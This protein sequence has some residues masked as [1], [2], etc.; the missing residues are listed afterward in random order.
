MQNTKYDSSDIKVLN[1]REHVRLRTNIYLGSTEPTEFNIP[2]FTNDKFQIKKIE[3]IPSV[4]KAVNEIL[5]NS[6]DE[7]AQLIKLNKTLTINSN[8][9]LGEYSISDNGRGIP[10]DMHETGKH[11]PEVVF[12]SLR[13][14][15][16]F[17]NERST[18]VIGVNGVGSSCT[19]YCSSYFHVNIHRDGKQYQQEFSDGALKVTKP[20]IKPSESPDTGTTISFQLDDKVFKKTS[21]PD[22]LMQNRAVEIALTN[23]GIIVNH[24]KQ[25][26][27]FNHG[28]DDIIKK[29]SGEYYK[30]SDE[31]MDWYVI[32]DT[33]E[34]IDEQIFT[35]VNSSLLFDG[36]ICNTQFQNAFYGASIE[37]LK[38]EAKKSKCEVTK[39]DIRTNL[40]IIGNLR[41]SDPSYDSQ[42]KTRLTS[43]GIRNE[44]DLMISKHWKQFVKKQSHWFEMVLERASRRHHS[45][46]DDKA[47]KDLERKVKKKVPGLIDATGDD[48]SKCILFVTEGD[49]ASSS[50][51]EVRTADIQGMMPLRGKVNNVY[52][53]SIAEILK[54][55]KVENLFAAMGLIPGKKAN[56][57]TMRFSKMIISTDADYDGSDIFA[58]LTNMFFILWPELFEPEN[59]VIYRLIVPNIVAIKGKKRVHFVNRNDYEKVRENYKGWELQYLKGL[60]SMELLDWEL[61]MNDI[62]NFIAP[63]I[64]DGNMSS[65]LELL[66]G[67]NADARKEWLRE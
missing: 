24:N 15:R 59:P 11:T 63:I 6:L 23:P 55:G 30:F 60:A 38:K 65:V 20:S 29:F 67:N 33:Y 34:G 22:E 61:I 57:K 41:L 16:N 27:R 52:G 51:R 26:Y 42:A 35:Y 32:F 5:D 28:F 62:D 64:D 50:L 21:L 58:L 53:S 45:S 31:N 40:L 48:R 66:F 2:V 4:F 1:D 49:S 9:I 8:S 47:M 44:L 25:R 17:K 43:P 14:G 13:S 56:R 37:H 12:G 39:N 3:F 54:M 36:G 19:N 7:F 10:I 18:G 46:A